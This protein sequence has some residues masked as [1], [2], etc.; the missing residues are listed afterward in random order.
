MC[1]SDLPSQ[2]RQAAEVGF[3][4]AFT[5]QV[6]PEPP[7]M[8]AL[9]CYVASPLFPFPDNDDD[10]SDLDLPVEVLAY[11]KAAK[12]VHPVA[13]SLPEDFRIIRRR[14]E[15]PLLSLPALPTHPPQFTP[16]TR[17]TQEHFD[18]LELNKFNFLWPEEV[19]LAAHV[20]KINEKALAWSEAERGRF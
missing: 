3:V 12:K 9:D 8:E 5:C 19:K 13:A 16:G 17:L 18:E 10:L 20:L 14:P 4:M 1:S 7:R 11:K 6:Q 2:A 15:D